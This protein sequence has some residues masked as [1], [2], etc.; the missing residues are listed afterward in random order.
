MT[1][2]LKKSYLKYL[3][4]AFGSAI[5]IS[6]YSTVDMICVGHYCG[7]DGSA[8]ISCITPLWNIMISLGLLL[9]IGGSAWLSNRR[10][11]GAREDSDMYF[12]LSTAVAVLVSVLLLVFLSIW[13]R[14]ALMLFGAEGQLVDL[15]SNYSRWIIWTTPA[16]LLGSHL[17]AFIRNDGC[18]VLCTVS[19][20][21]GGVVNMVCDV[22]FT[23]DFGLG[24]G[25][26]GA[27]MATAL[28]QT[29]AFLI[30]L[31]YFFS[32]RCTLRLVRPKAVLNKLSRICA[33]GFPPFVT[34]FCYGIT[35]TLFNRQ[36]MRYAGNTELA[37]YGTV[38]TVALLFQSLFYAVGTAIQPIASVNHGAGQKDRVRQLLRLG[39]GTSLILGALFFALSILFPETI[40]RI[41]MDVD[42]G[43]LAIGPAA[44][45]IY[46]ISFPLMGLNLVISYY[47]QSILLNRPSLVISLLR[48]VLLCSVLVFILPAALGFGAIWWTMVVTEV[49]TL[50]FSLFALR[51]HLKTF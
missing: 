18:P 24:L 37:V 48:G 31:G 6:I 39:L 47:L 21:V 4:S 25:I 35:V 22:L 11:A 41:Y 13:R 38:A 49:L 8:A 45:R 29:V 28:G 32:K 5:I 14:Q 27:G 50:I 15:A 26:S 12:T 2:N 19:V 23:F 16:F 7:P 36:I 40:L 10:G 20:I 43:V 33:A 17:T 44:M 46:G 9:G 1:G 51:R 34:D 30:L 3:F 42:A